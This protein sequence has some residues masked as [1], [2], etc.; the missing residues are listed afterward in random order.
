MQQVIIA[1]HLMVVTALVI[2]ILYQKSEGGALGMGGSG[3]FT[4][5]GQANALTRATGILATI[6]FLTSIALTVLPAWQRRAEGGDDWT[7]AIDQGDIK[8]R[9]IKPG[10]KAPEPGKES[11]F[12]QLQRAQQKRT[13]G[14][15]ASAPAE[16]K[17]GLRPSQEPPK[18]EIPK[19][20]PKDAPKPAIPAAEAPKVDAAK[21]ADAPKAEPAMEAPKA[22]A[23]AAQPPQPEAP[24]AETPAEKPAEA[25]PAA[26][27]QW[28]SPTQ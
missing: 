6:F 12:D 3:V 23:P 27:T 26:P 9:E 7:K 20:A 5:R 13:Q 2:L 1:I 10:E 4:G 14:A 15:G 8:F 24:K 11:V 16:E 17:P 21:P 28:K 25:K 22:E 19:D 18:A